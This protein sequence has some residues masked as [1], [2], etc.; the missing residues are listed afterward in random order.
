MC[1]LH[2]FTVSLL[3][4]STQ[5]PVLTRFELLQIGRT[6][7]TLIGHAQITKKTLCF[8]QAFYEFCSDTISRKL[9]ITPYM[10][11]VGTLLWYQ[12]LPK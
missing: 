1:D 3:V 4:G 5:W 11:S 10:Y 6:V 2:D 8:G 9:T 12:T 7:A